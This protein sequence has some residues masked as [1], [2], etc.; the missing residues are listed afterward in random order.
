M[1]DDEK[2]TVRPKPCAACPY[3][4]DVPSGVWAESEY[5]RLR[6]YDGDITDQL[7][8]GAVRVFMCHQA[9]GKLCAGWAGC[10]GVINTAAGR[11]HAHRLDESVWSYE[12]PV[13][14][15][16]SGAEAADHG[17]AEIEKPSPEAVAVTRKIV[18]LRDARGEPVKF[19]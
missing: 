16:D 17:E 11:M 18:T 9:D 3:R 14:L 7:R 4:R 13:P 19:S 6:Q 1:K 10:H 2:I 8:K 5:E 15:F 12:S